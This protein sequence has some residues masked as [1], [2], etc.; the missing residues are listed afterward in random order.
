MRFLGV[1]LCLTSLVDGLGA[2]C[3]AGGCT[4]PLSRL[5]FPASA[6]FHAGCPDCDPRAG[7]APAPADDP[8]GCPGHDEGGPA[9]PCRLCSSS[10]AVFVAPAAVE[11]PDPFASP[12]ARVASADDFVLFFTSAPAAKA[13]P[14]EGPSERDA[15]RLRALLQV[16]LI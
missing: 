14:P 16:F 3:T 10:H 8:H 5:L 13:A 1:A 4:S 9:R 15:G 12:A 7:R 11:P 6:G 2:A